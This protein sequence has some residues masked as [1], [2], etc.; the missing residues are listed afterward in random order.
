MSLQSRIEKDFVAAY[1]A[2]ETVKVAVLRMLKT[3]IKNQQVELGRPLE[4]DEVLDL[5]SK[6]VKQRHESITQYEKAGREELAETE[7]VELAEL[8]S[9]MPKALTDEELAE[10]IEEAVAETGADSMKDMGKV[11]GIL[12]SKYKGRYDGKMA[13]ELVRKRLAG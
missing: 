1:K 5:V 3:A 9:Y 6:Q 7:R 8:Q 2:K 10:A 12:G 13:S 11:M 4:D